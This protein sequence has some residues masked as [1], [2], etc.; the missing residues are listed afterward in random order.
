MKLIDILKQRH[1]NLICKLILFG[2]AII[3]ASFTN[4]ADLR[5]S[6]GGNFRSLVIEGPIEDGD[7]DRF[8]ELIRDGRGL[9]SFVVIYSPGG[10]FQEEM[11][12]GRAMRALELQSQVPI[13]NSKG[14]PECNE[15]PK[16]IPIPKDPKN[17]TAAS[18][19]F[20]IHIGGISR[21]GKFFAVHRPYYDQKQFSK[22]TKSQAQIAYDDLIRLTRDYML[23]MGV[24]PHVQEEILSVPSDKYKVLEEKIVDNYFLGPIPSWFEWQKSKCPPIS[25]FDR[26]RLDELSRKLETQQN[27]FTKENLTEIRTLNE[28]KDQVSTCTLTLAEESRLASYVKFFGALPGTSP[29]ASSTHK[30]SI[31]V[32]ATKYLGQSFEDIESEERFESAESEAKV[33]N[34]YLPSGQKISAIAREATSRTPRVI[35]YDSSKRKRYVSKFR[36]IHFD[37]SDE[38]VNKLVNSLE[39]GLGKPIGKPIKSPTD[40]KWT[41]KLKTGYATLQL[42]SPPSPFLVYEFEEFFQR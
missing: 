22:L 8:L 30:F 31:W 3:F 23:E 42:Y 14:K 6:V 13:R 5:L 39:A 2:F 29:S 15:Y 21:W 1:I 38:F 24:P 41:W 18:A 7:Y 10:D 40:T 20:F 12:I 19:A 4:A 32:D 17:C 9:V 28:K 35:L 16:I 26:S 36:V 33:F 34:A 27:N 11:K 25:S 37:T